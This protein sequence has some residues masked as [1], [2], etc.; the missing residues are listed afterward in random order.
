MTFGQPQTSN[1]LS[2]NL[3]Q[4]GAPLTNGYPGYA[5][6]QV[7]HAN[8]NAP[9][10]AQNWLLELIQHPISQPSDNTSWAWQLPEPE[11]LLEVEI[12][13]KID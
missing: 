9:Q 11:T 1:G 4:T 10:A 8:Y 13:Q 2:L 6:P 12:G 7:S 3:S 5:A